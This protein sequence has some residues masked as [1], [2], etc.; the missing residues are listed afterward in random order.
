M[1]PTLAA[2]AGG[3]GGLVEQATRLEEAMMKARCYSRGFNFV[4]EIAQRH[5]GT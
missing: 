2:G 4:G 5:G 1:R 3:R